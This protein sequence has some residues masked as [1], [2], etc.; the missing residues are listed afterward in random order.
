MSGNNSFENRL[1]LS[2]DD[3]TPTDVRAIF[4]RASQLKVKGFSDSAMMNLE[5]GTAP[6][7]ALAF[8][9]PSTRTK[10]SF[11][12]AAQRLGCKTIGFD[13]PESTSSAKGEQLYDTIKVIEQYADV[14]VIR[15]KDDDTPD[16]IRDVA[17]KPVISAG[18]GA[19]EHPTQALL[20]VF[21]MQEQRDL[22]SINHVV[23]YG[24][25]LNSRT[26]VS[27]VKLLA[28]DGMEFSFVSPQDM[29]ISTEL[30]QD[31]VSRGASVNK[32]ENL[33]DV[34]A[35][36][37]VLHVIRPQRERW[38]GK[39]HGAYKPVDNQALARM[40]SDALVLHALPRTG[41]LDPET[42]ND[43]RNVIWEQVQNG[44]YVRA[45][46]LEWILS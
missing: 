17:Q 12:A 33:D 37:D 11:D 18:V 30:Q 9:E 25:L 38:E 41:E 32:V 13:N 10:L 8:F 5:P 23:S 21:T 34:I 28:R 44:I 43:P 40:K 24:D 1:V 46:L 19:V 36:A 42:D 39:E 16:I 2:V 15:R 4:E 6:V 14:L 27:Q 3:L 26:M 45:A 22:S 20:D 29:Q 7:V 31:L 35:D